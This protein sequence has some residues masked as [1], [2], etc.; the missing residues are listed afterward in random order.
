MNQPEP[1]LI[2]REYKNYEK[3]ATFATVNLLGIWADKTANLARIKVQVNYSVQ[4]GA[5]INSFPEFALSGY[6][7]GEEAQKEHKP[8]SMHIKA[9][10][11]TPSLWPL[12]LQYKD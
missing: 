2:P 4:L 1:D 12:E 6:E 5:K 3:S 8:C 11:T 9:A 10:E 7:G